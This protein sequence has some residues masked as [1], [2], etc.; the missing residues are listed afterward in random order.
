MAH[1]HEMDNT[2]CILIA[3]NSEDFPLEPKL[4]ETPHSIQSLRNM[5]K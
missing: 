1:Y 5:V 3:I 2:D 4:K